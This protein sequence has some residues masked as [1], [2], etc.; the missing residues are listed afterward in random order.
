MKYLIIIFFTLIV[1]NCFSKDTTSLK[2][3]IGQIAYIHP[4]L[5]KNLLDSLI[6]NKMMMLENGEKLIKYVIGETETSTNQF[7][8][9][10]EWIE[11]KYFNQKYF[12]Y[13]PCNMQNQYRIKIKDSTFNFFGYYDFYTPQ[14]K[15]FYSPDANTFSFNLISKNYSDRII[16]FHIIDKSLN[17][18]VVEEKVDNMIFYKLMISVHK[19]KQLPIVESVCDGS[20]MEFS[21]E[22]PN[23]KKLIKGLPINK[24]TTYTNA[25]NVALQFLKWFYFERNKSMQFDFIIGGDT[26]NKV[27]RVNF[28]EA[29]KY[30]A[31]S[32][33]CKQLSTYFFTSLKRYFKIID[34]SFIKHPQFNFI[35][36]GFE[37]DLI[38]K[39][40][41]D[42]GIRSNINR[43][44]ITG[45]KR[46]NSNKINLTLAFDKY[47]KIKF[48]LSKVKSSWKIDTVNGDFPKKISLPYLPPQK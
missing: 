1:Q 32:K 28:D 21:F 12:A 33:S 3:N 13:K 2:N 34:N 11:I 9:A 42:F 43:L 14:I 31:Y 47:S 37:T 16:T 35:P 17:I 45:I 5:N 10:N 27:Y 23:Y 41:D 8:I 4:T 20:N 25:K 6:H 44:S 36:N 18:A 30:I 26:L 22:E 24:N 19:V 48:L 46:I 38:I 7:L 15:S 29:N 40:Q 39:N